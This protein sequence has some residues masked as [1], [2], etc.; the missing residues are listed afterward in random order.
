MYS[1]FV[2][3]LCTA[4]V[5]ILASACHSS[6]GMSSLYPRVQACAFQRKQVTEAEGKLFASGEFFPLPPWVGGKGC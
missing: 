5:L 2:F 3:D 6:P 1:N 4:L